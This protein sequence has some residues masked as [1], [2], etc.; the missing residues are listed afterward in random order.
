M[1]NDYDKLRAMKACAPALRWIGDRTIEQAWREC[2]HGGWMCWLLRRI[3]RT[4]SLEG[5]IDAA[6]GAPPR[7]GAA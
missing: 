2:E 6:T 7:A 3:A 5:A 4:D 1:T